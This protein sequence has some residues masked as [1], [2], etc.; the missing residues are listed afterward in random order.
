MSD[1][2]VIDA[3]DLQLENR[4]AVPHATVDTSSI[5]YQQEN[6]TAMPSKHPKQLS[7]NHE[8]KTRII[9]ALEN[10][11]WNRKAASRELGLTYRQLRYRIKQ[12]RLDQSD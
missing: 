12:L 6:S 10:N 5:A 4:T 3:A 2:R 11:R 8:E 9:N 1:D 7:T